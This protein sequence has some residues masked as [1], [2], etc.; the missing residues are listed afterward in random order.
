MFI[1]DATVLAAMRPPAGGGSSITMRFLRHFNVIS[2]T[3][4]N[5][6]TITEIFSKMTKHFLKRF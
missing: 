5:E 6:K 4:L 3:E 1:E 2:Y